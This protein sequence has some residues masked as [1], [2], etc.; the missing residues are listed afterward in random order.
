LSIDSPPGFT[1]RRL[2]VEILEDIVDVTL[3]TLFLLISQ[4][5]K[6]EISSKITNPSLSSIPE[7]FYGADEKTFGCEANSAVQR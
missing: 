6:N 5:S 7:I 1:R 2:A 4:V 3:Q